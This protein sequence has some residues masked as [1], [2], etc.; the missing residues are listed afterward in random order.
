MTPAVAHSAPLV[1]A[2]ATIY[3]STHRRYARG[4]AGSSRL[5]I[6]FEQVLLWLQSRHLSTFPTIKMEN[7]HPVRRSETPTTHT[8][9]SRKSISEFLAQE[10]NSRQASSCQQCVILQLREPSPAKCDTVC[11]FASDRYACCPPVP[12]PT[13]HRTVL[14]N[15]PCLT[16]LLPS[17][18]PLAA[19]EL[20]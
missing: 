2:C 11:P 13:A 12:C 7:I 6:Y 8:C 14:R 10:P 1:R 3:I 4:I 17:S 16:M 18:F 9:I 20:K 5:C 19:S 15:F